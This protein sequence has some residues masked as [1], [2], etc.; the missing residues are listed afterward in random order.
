MRVTRVATV[1]DL[2]EAL[3]GV[4]PRTPVEHGFDATS[5]WYAE[6]G[7]AG[8]RTGEVGVRVHGAVTILSQPPEPTNCGCD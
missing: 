2:I 4:D 7:A 1:G 6:P 8:L 5:P 3:S